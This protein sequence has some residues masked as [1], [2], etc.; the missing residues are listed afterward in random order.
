MSGYGV[1]PLCIIGLSMPRSAG[2][3]RSSDRILFRTTSLMVHLSVEC[4]NTRTYLQMVRGAPGGEERGTAAERR[5]ELEVF[6]YPRRF[7]AQASPTQRPL[8]PPGVLQ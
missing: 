5:H 1:V 8:P 6:R 2:L 4:D 3:T 7:Q